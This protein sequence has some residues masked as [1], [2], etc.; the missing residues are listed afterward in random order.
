LSPENQKNGSND[1]NKKDDTDQNKTVTKGNGTFEDV[2]SKLGN[3]LSDYP[4]TNDST[5]DKKPAVSNVSSQDSY[6]NNKKSDN[7]NKESDDT[8]NAANSTDEKSKKKTYKIIKCKE[9]VMYHISEK[10]KLMYMVTSNEHGNDVYITV[11]V[12][13]TDSIIYI[14]GGTYDKY[15]SFIKKKSVLK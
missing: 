10:G 1:N 4:P 2:L 9:S 5:A 3:G 6:F 7:I 14:D 15:K 11:V 12:N 8:K 13:K